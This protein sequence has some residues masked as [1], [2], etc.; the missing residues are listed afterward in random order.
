MR[1]FHSTEVD[2]F[3]EQ[4]GVVPTGRI[5]SHVWMMYSHEMRSKSCRAKQKS[6][7]I[8]RRC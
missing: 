5:T 7:A 8:S 6:R 2:Q 3:Y 1:S 4:R